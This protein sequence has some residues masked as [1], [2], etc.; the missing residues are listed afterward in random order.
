MWDLFQWA[1]AGLPP[2]GAPNNAHSGPF[3]LGVLARVRPTRVLYAQPH[4]QPTAANSS[5]KLSIEHARDLLEESEREADLDEHAPDARHHPQ[6]QG[7]NTPAVGKELKR[8]F[9]V[10]AAHAAMHATSMRLLS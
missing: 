3:A 7:A 8:L 1:R 4:V 10:N 9:A 5:G 6:E 2:V